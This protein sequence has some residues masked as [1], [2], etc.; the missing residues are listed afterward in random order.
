LTVTERYRHGFDVFPDSNRIQPFGSG[1]TCV[2]NYRDLQL[3]NNTK[4]TYQLKLYVDDENLF[5][6]LKSTAEPKCMYEVYEKDH[7]I[8]HEFWGGYVRHNTIY[9]RTY[10]L[11]GALIKDEL[12]AEN[13]AV[14]MY[15]PFLSESS[16]SKGAGI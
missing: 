8:S 2:Y 11:D 13:N 7:H 16:S 3:Y 10:D 9:R 14:M 4:D 15:Q 6:E 5:G 1:A 12:L